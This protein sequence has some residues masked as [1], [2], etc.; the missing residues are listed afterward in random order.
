MGLV[1]DALVPSLRHPM[2]TA[3]AVAWAALA[4]SQ[5]AIAI[6]SGFTGRISPGERPI[7][8][9]DVAAYAASLGSLLRR[10]GRDVAGTNGRFN[11]LQHETQR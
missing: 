9:D 6:S 7:K 1:S 11:I 2:V 8:W 10:G 5:V 4:P 3:A